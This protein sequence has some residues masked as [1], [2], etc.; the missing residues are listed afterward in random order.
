MGGLPQGVPDPLPLPRP[1]GHP[2]SLATIRYPRFKVELNQGGG[3]GRLNRFVRRL[4]NEEGKSRES[5]SSLALDKEILSSGKAAN[6]CAYPFF[7]EGL[8][9]CRRCEVV[10][11]RLQEMLSRP[12]RP[13]NGAP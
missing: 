9:F 1:S 7:W 3:S 6:G 8:D 12:G 5:R 10:H 13:G 11:E 2:G 4:R